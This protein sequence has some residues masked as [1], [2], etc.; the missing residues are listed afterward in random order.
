MIGIVAPSIDDFSFFGK[1]RLLAE[2]VLV[3][4]Q[5]GHAFRYTDAFGVIPGAAANTIA[6]ID[7]A[8]AARSRS[9]G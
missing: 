4:V 2:V 7:G 5:I 1:R 3:T 6:R 9:A 8:V